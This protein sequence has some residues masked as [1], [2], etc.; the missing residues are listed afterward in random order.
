MPQEEGTERRSAAAVLATPPP[1]PPRPNSC[2]QVVA[3]SSQDDMMAKQAAARVQAIA[4]HTFAGADRANKVRQCSA[5]RQQGAQQQR[6]PDSSD[7]SA[8]LHVRGA[9]RPCWRRTRAT[10][11]PSLPRCP[12]PQVRTVMAIGPAPAEQLEQ[13]VAALP[14][15]A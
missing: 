15:L 14:E 4:T 6:R 11:G 8:T 2:A 7:C 9:G 5:T 12:A 1:A 10:R 3:V 13:V